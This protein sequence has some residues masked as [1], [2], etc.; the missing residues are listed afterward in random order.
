VH[1]D[2]QVFVIFVYLGALD[3]AQTVLKVQGME[4]IVASQVLDVLMSRLHDIDPTNLVLDDSADA[5]ILASS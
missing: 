2:E 5:H 1:H 4:G 3:V